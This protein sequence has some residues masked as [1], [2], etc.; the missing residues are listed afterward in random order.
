MSKTLL[1]ENFT[2]TESMRAWAQQ[3]VPDIDLEEH[4]ADFC[5]WFRARGRMMVDWEATWR[6]WMR[7]AANSVP[8]YREINRP[9]RPTTPPATLIPDKRI[10]KQ[11]Q[12]C[13]HGLDGGCV[14]CRGLVQ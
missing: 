1:P 13:R 5:D 7:R 11:R 10:N 14:Y 8:G 12:L 2:I 9:P 6:T 4:T 3:K